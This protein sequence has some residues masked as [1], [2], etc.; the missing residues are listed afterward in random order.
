MLAY[1]PPAFIALN[2]P[3]ASLHPD[4]MEPLA[5][6][7]VT[8]SERTQ[9]WVVTHSQPLAAA[10]ER[11]GNVRPRSVIKADGATTI[12][13]LKLGGFEEE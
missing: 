11:F 12:A 8:A 5:R 2:E 13:G 7:I 3:E 1:R 9:V 10:I 6:M 4:L